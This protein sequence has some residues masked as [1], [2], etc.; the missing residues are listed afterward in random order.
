MKFLFSTGVFLV[1]VLWG[2]SEPESGKI[3]NRK[4]INIPASNL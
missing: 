2:P 3:L 1:I 4:K